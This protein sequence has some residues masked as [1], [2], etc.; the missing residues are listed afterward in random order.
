[1]TTTKGTEMSKLVGV[2]I[3]SVKETDMDDKVTKQQLI[4][5]VTE[6]KA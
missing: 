2:I 1:M 3:Y 4:Q 6:K 5:N